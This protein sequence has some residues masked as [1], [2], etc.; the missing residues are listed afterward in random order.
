[1]LFYA[2]VIYVSKD[3]EI[4]LST[5]TFDITHNALRRRDGEK[6]YTG[7]DWWSSECTANT[8][9]IH[10][11]TIWDTIC[12]SSS[13]HKSMSITPCSLIKLK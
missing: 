8:N 6:A 1:M 5:V 12:S 9:V 10:N 11:R 7:S 3:D 13:N 4:C 2:K